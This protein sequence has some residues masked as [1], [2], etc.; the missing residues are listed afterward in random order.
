MQDI[1]LIIDKPKALNMQNKLTS[2]SF[3]FVLWLILFYL[4]QPLISLI[5]WGFG[6]KIFYEHM[7]ILGGLEGFIEMLSI[8]FTII[9]ILGGGLLLW[10][11]TNKLRFRGKVRRTNMDKVTS[12]DV[13]TYFKISKKK[14]DLW[15]KQKNI[16]IAIT[17][18]FQI[19]VKINKN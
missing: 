11:Y 16:S 19:F 3:T 13:A 8:Y 14:H 7:I 4:W 5:A 12:V 15:M 17:D 9:S 2:F 1:E 6:F 10:A 18:D